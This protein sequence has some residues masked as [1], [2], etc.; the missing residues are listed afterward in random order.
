ML[1]DTQVHESEI[2][3]ILELGFGQS[4]NFESKVFSGPEQLRSTTPEAECAQERG[5]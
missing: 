2:C 1:F 5:I 4:D 3:L